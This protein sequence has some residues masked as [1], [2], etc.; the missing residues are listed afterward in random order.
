MSD[1]PTTETVKVEPT[2]GSRL[3][4]MHAAY[5]DAKAAADDATEKL[6]AITDAIKLELSQ[7]A[8]EGATKVDLVGPGPSLRLSWS[9]TWRF[10]SRRFKAEDPETYVRYAKKSGAW[11]L[12]AA[13]GGA[14]E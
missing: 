3:E 11:T 2:P 14:S 12:R 6:K 8:P 9:E 13:A 4:Q 1:Q 7:A 5:A 10:D